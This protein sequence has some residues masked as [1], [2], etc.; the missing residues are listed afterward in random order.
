MSKTK[1]CPICGAL[2]IRTKY[3]ENI[4]MDTEESTWQKETILKCQGCSHME[5][6]VENVIF[7]KSKKKCPVC[8]ILME[9]VVYDKRAKSVWAGHKVFRCNNCKHCE[10]KRGN[11]IPFF[12]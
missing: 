6:L 2:M 8:N 1:K 9:E 5:D 7:E 4:G 11:E 12:L 3:P 10:S